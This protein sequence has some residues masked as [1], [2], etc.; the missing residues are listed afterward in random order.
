ME[1]YK[2]DRCVEPAG[3][4]GPLNIFPVNETDIKRILSSYSAIDWYKHVLLTMYYIL[5]LI[6]AC[7]PTA[8]SVSLC[9]NAGL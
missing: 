6:H 3:I 2:K 1:H 7:A 8:G 4:S 9:S 5:H